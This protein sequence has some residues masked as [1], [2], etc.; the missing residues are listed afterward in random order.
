VLRKPVQS[1]DLAESLQ[2]VLKAV[3]IPTVRLC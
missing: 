1:R 2:R 3:R